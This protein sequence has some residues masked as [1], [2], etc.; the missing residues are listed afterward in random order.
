MALLTGMTEDGREV[1]VQVDGTGRLVAEGLQ[2]PK[3]DAGTDGK[4]AAELW[5][6]NGSDLAPI[7]AKD[8]VYASAGIK[9]G[10]T[11]NAPT[12]TLNGADGG[13]YFLGNVG[14]GTSIP[15]E[16]IDIKG[17]LRVSDST[18][19]DSGG[20][21]RI[22]TDAGKSYIDALAN[23][24]GMW[25][26][27]YLRGTS[28]KVDTAPRGAIPLERLYITDSGDVLIGGMLPGNPQLRV[29]SQGA[30]RSQALAVTVHADNAAAVAAGLVAGDF[31]RKPDGTLMVA[32]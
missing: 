32:F 20:R 22:G 25:Q 7:S 26:Q 2:G 30:I 24:G 5:V 10:G 19:G 3:G 29:S 28:L 4:N 13:G 15:S 18:G 21:I 1:P 16:A 31:Y 23:T 11:P 17:F 8:S 27:L 9:A 14:F 12:V 6:R